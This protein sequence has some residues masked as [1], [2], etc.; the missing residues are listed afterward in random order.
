[1]LFLFITLS[2]S[3]HSFP[4]CKV[5]V[6]RSA[7]SFMYVSFMYVSFMY[8]SLYV[9]CCFSLA[10]FNM[11]YLCLIFISLINTYINVF[12]FGF[13]LYEV[14]W[15]SLTW[16]AISFHRLEK[17]LNIIASNIFPAFF[18]LFS[19]G[20]HMIWIFACLMLYQKSLRLFL[21]IFILFFFI[22]FCFK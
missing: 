8:V 5:S 12:L 18:G 20:T 7:V 22:A 17:F 1:L 13:I 6:E 4:A 11:C 19:S 21:L 16:L 14:L 9:T 2:I 3:C 15:I 10:A